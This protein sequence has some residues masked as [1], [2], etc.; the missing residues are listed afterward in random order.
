MRFIFSL[1]ISYYARKYKYS[2][3][4]QFVVYNVVQNL[5]KFS[6]LPKVVTWTTKLNLPL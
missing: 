5:L 4:Q 6:E 1:Y 2:R 3:I